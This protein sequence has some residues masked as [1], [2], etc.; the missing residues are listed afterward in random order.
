MNAGVC[1]Q[2]LGGSNTASKTTNTQPV[3]TNNRSNESFKK[4]MDK[5]FD[6]KQSTINDVSKSNISKKVH[7]KND[8]KKYP[9]NDANSVKNDK[10]TDP[11]QEEQ[12][13]AA[14]QIQQSVIAAENIVDTGDT[15]QLLQSRGVVNSLLATISGKTESE[16]LSNVAE[17]V[18][19]KTKLPFQNNV[20]LVKSAM[21]KSAQVGKQENQ[22]QNYAE[23]LI[24]SNQM[25]GENLQKNENSQVKVANLQGTKSDNDEVTLGISDTPEENVVVKANNLDLSKVN[26]KVAETPIDTTRTDMTKQLADKIMYKLNEGKHEFDLELNPKNLGKVNIKMIFQNGCAELLMTTSNSK[27]HHLL[28]MQADTLRGILEASTGTDNNVT[29]KQTEASEGQ[30]DRDNFQEQSKG[31]QNQQQQRQE[32]NLTGDIS[33]SDRLRLGLIDGLDEAV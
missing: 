13:L 23:T 5:A 14:S 17:D 9:E 4:E 8:S 26:I 1:F 24:N 29:V 30:F 20:E 2:M 6:R 28:S 18:E 19:G 22:R 16:D 15:L 7:D 12:A 11:S 33:F 10:N 27:A 31:Q 3:Q 21:L 25:Q 32:K